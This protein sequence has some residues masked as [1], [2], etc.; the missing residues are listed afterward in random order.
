MCVCVCSLLTACV[1]E[2]VCV[3][4]CTYIQYIVHYVCVCV[5]LGMSGEWVVRDQ[6]S[7][8]SSHDKEPSY[9]QSLR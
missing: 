1:S 8:M 9:H 6:M 2:F 5:L 3:F 7:L 4:V